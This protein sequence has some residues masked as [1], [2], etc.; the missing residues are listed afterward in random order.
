MDEL[1]C[2]DENECI[3]NNGHG[4]CQDTCI[5]TDGSFQC[6][7]DGLPGTILSADGKSCEEIDLC[8][9]NNGGC[10]HDCHTSYGQSF[11]MC[12]TGMKLDI[13]W[14]TCISQQTG[15][16][17]QI[18]EKVKC[19]DGYLLDKK[20]NECI[21]IDE[22]AKPQ[23]G[24]HGYCVNEQPG[25][26]CDCFQGYEFDGTTCVDKNECLENMCQN[27]VCINKEGSFQCKCFEGYA[28]D[29]YGICIDIDECLEDNICGGMGK[30]IN[31]DGGFDC[32]CQSGYENSG[33]ICV[34]INECKHSKC[35]KGAHCVNL[36]GSYECDCKRP[37][38][39]YDSVHKKC[40][41]INCP[42]GTCSKNG[43]CIMDGSIFKCICKPGFTGEK[44]EHDI[45][46]CKSNP[47]QHKCENTGNN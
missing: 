31:L 43:K 19:K 29:S 3:S 37:D 11:C 12:P 1:K 32:D 34:D 10:S 27:G 36:E 28:Q 5:N 44:C 18:S 38:R 8:K 16:K 30:C 21:D 7:C 46:E 15:G 26:K 45:N 40:K 14:K 2:V 13:D 35:G 9:E 47:C 20:S 4:P 23:C 41:K 42:Q 17:V 39:I 25:Y 24:T 22:C 33:G 6:A